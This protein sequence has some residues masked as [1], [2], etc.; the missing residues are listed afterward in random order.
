MGII[1]K[2]DEGEASLGNEST[3]EHDVEVTR[4]EEQDADDWDTS[5]ENPYNWPAWK[6][7]LQVVMLSSSAILAYVHTLP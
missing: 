5:L 6:K 1:T 2:Q 4:P 7:A 3:T